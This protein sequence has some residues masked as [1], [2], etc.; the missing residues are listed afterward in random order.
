MVA[1][2]ERS[3]GRKP[4]TARFPLAHQQRYPWRT[5][6]AV[7]SRLISDLWEHLYTGEGPNPASTDP[8]TPGVLVHI[9]DWNNY[10]PH[11]PVLTVGR[12]APP[13]RF[14]KLCPRKE[15]P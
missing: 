2:P 6:Y 4:Q 1:Q 3:S 5:L 13:V 11:T 7:G 14:R 10:P 12:L 8:D 9:V 15:Q